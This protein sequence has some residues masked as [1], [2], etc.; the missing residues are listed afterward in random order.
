MIEPARLI[1]VH[2][3]WHGAWSWDDVRASLGEV[4]AIA[5]DLPMRSLDEDVAVV[6]AAID[7]VDGPV[8][9]VGHSYGGAV[10]TAAGE[11]PAVRS[12]VYLAAFQLEAGESISRVRPDLAIAP[13]ELGDALRFSDDRSLVSIDPAMARHILY[14]QATDEQ[15]AAALARL[16]PASRSL[17]SARAQTTAWRGRRSSYVVCTQ[18]TCVAPDLQRAMAERATVRFEWPADHSCPLSQPDRVAGL[19][20]AEASAA[21]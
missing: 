12:L 18:D 9:L 15:A 1:L 4:D 6:R 11:S 10:I 16:R 14:G 2:G 17:F 3:L 20:R 19:L 7:T 8:T 21:T 13:T 5:V